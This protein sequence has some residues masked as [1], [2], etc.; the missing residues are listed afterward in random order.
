ALHPEA[1]EYRPRDGAEDGRGDHP[2]VARDAGL[3]DQHEDDDARAIGGH[4]ADEGADALGGVGAGVQVHLLRSTRFPGDGKVVEACLLARPPLLLAGA[5]GRGS[6]G[7]VAAVRALTTR[8]TTAGS[9]AST[10]SPSRVSTRRTREGRTR[11]PPFAI[12]AKAAAI[13]SGVTDTPCPKLCVARAIRAHP[14]TGRRA[15]G[16][17]P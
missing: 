15:P 8:R 6:S 10:T 12:A 7:T 16:V 11:R 5:A 9:F 4:E 1:L 2:A 14:P 13:W 3:V 17:A